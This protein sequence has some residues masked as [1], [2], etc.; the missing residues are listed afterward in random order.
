LIG[1]SESV[2]IAIRARIN[3]EEHADIRNTDVDRSDVVL[4]L[5]LRPHPA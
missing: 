2:D 4:G 5:N 1:G 3:I